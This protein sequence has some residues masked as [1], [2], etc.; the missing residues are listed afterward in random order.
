MTSI[1]C[2]PSVLFFIH[3]FKFPFLVCTLLYVALAASFTCLIANFRQNYGLAVVE[4]D[5]SC[6]EMCAA[7][8]ANDSV[9]RIYAEGHDRTKGLQ[10][11]RKIVTNEFKSLVPS[12]FGYI[13]VAI[14]ID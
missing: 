12:V 5:A 13:L 14:S 11:L 1:N 7:L 2:P 10:V 9:L 6:A 4:G 3:P 8:N